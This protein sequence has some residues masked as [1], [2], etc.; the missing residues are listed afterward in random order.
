MTQRQK[1]QWHGCRLDNRNMEQQ[2][3]LRLQ[4]RAKAVLMCEAVQEAHDWRMLIVPPSNGTVP[5]REKAKRVIRCDT[6]PLVLWNLSQRKPKAPSAGSS[7]GFRP[8]RPSSRAL[9]I[10]DRHI[11]FCS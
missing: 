1:S 8:F 6:A 7:I 11:Q 4:R 5:P 2:D 9:H 3:A 10:I